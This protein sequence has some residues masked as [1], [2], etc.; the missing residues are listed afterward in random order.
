MLKECVI[1]PEESKF[2]RSKIR[3]IGTCHYNHSKTQTMP[4]Y[5]IRN[6]LDL[7]EIHRNDPDKLH[8][9]SNGRNILNKKNSINITFSY[10][11]EH[12]GFDRELVA[13]T[14][15][16]KHFSMFYST[17]IVVDTYSGGVPLNNPVI[18]STI[19]STGSSLWNDVTIRCFC[20]PRIKDLNLEQL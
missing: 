19:H 5:K 12:P 9:A 10:K 17:V 16:D 18:K 1:L 8:T 3:V 20:V 4:L 11:Y 14:V 13:N 6:C 2:Q 7:P 15:V